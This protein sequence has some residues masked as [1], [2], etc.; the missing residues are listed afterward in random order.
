MCVKLHPTVSL[1][2]KAEFA[3]NTF[4]FIYA[5]RQRKTEAYL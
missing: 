3:K 5:L 1:S 4:T 2:I